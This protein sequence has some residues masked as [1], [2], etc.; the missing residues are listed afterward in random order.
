MEYIYELITILTAFTNLF[1]MI[2]H[3]HSTIFVH[4]PKNAGQSVEQVF[5][6]DLGLSWEDRIVLLMGINTS[7]NIGPPRLAH[8]LARDY[9]E[10]SFISQ[11]LFDQYFKFAIVRNPWSRVYSF[12]K[13]LTKQ[14]I[15]FN[16]F[17]KHRFYKDYFTSDKYSWF[18]RPQADYLFDDNDQLL[19][20]YVGRFE[21]IDE[22]FNHININL[23]FLKFFCQIKIFL[24]QKNYSTLFHSVCLHQRLFR[25][26]TPK[27]I[28]II[29][30]T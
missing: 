14:R 9:I 22:H 15:E 12:Y 1:L 10:K 19:V 30:L 24:N 8:L 4:I 29:L 18:V 26:H 7:P 3:K 16:K 21:S 27:S 5:L 13:F 11:E 23:P 28:M 6:N 25:Y 2:S 20:N 17:L